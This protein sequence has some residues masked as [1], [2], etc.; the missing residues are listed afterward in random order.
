MAGAVAS[1]LAI[2]AWLG[3]GN[4]QELKEWVVSDG[5]SPISTATPTTYT[6]QP[7]PTLPQPEPTPTVESTFGRDPGCTAGSAATAAANAALEGDVSHSQLVGIASSY[8]DA[9][10][11]AHDADVR[12]A[13]TAVAADMRFFADAREAGNSDA[14]TSI[15]KQLSIDLDR[16]LVACNPKPAE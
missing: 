7:M 3:A 12:S 13:L 14:M 10:D 15:R 5:S 11:A 1:V 4:M 8:T 6:P 9:A 2:V 16:Y